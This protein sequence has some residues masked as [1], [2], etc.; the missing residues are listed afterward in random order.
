MSGF[1]LLKITSPLPLLVNE[2][3]DSKVFPPAEVTAPAPVLVMLTAWLK[4][5]PLNDTEAEFTE[6]LTSKV[7]PA[8]MTVP[9]Q[10]KLPLVIDPPLK[11]QLPATARVKPDKFS[12]PELM[13][14]LLIPVTSS[15]NGLNVPL[16]MVTSSPMSGVPVAGDQLAGFP[17][18]VDTPPIQV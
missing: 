9:V 17:H 13:V 7:V 5:E 1:V 3:V 15:N 6:T 14:K 18:S 4:V 2:K 8:K 16:C 10:F 12:E 11:L